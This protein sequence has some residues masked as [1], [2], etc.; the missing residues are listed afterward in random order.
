MSTP[1]NV[2][3]L[4]SNSAQ[5]V[6]KLPS[7]VF[8]GNKTDYEHSPLFFGQDAGLLD[9]VNK[10]RVRLME[11]FRELRSLDWDD[12][13][14]DFGS[15]AIDFEIAKKEASLEYDMMIK[16]L[17]WQWE[18]DSMA[19]RSLAGIMANVVTDSELWLGI[20]KINENENIHALT[21]SEIVRNSFANPN[22]ALA[23]ILEVK[24]ALERLHAVADVMKEAHRVSHMYALNMIQADQVA[25]NAIFMFCVAM[26]FLE[27]IQFMAS[28]SV[29]FAI[30][31]LGRFQPIGKAV[32]RIA[33]DEFEIHSQFQQEVLR[34]ELQTERGRIAYEQCKPMIIALWREVVACELGWLEYLF[35]GDRELP[36]YTLAKGK[37]WVLFNAATPAKFLGFYEDIKDDYA[38]P[39]TNPLV[40]MEEYLDVSSTQSAPQE[41]DS[42]S[43]RVNVMTRTDDNVDFD[44]EL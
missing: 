44:F 26:Y 22:T 33:Q 13:E 20:V 35:A 43:Y 6:E 23:E 15:C 9:T 21:Y 7:K 34:I 19:S 36:G 37:Q 28:F 3:A 1:E 24:E 8:N 25:Y 30:C 42:A 40:F 14:F 2:P 16:T 32:E 38:F 12:T 4:Y 17:L 11:L 39:T 29:T 5:Y 10:K 18:A 31:R 41:E 27:R